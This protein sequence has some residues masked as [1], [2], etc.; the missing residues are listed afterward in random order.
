MPRDANTAKETIHTP[1][2]M[3]QLSKKS[4]QPVAGKAPGPVIADE[5][6]T[7]NGIED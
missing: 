3:P 5:G 6:H 4:D 1:E 2:K 7:I